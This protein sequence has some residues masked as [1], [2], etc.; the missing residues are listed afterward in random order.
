MDAELYLRSFRQEQAVL[1]RQRELRRTI[2]ERGG[3]APA[4]RGHG[5]R[6]VTGRAAGTASGDAL[7]RAVDRVAGW[8][9]RRHVAVRATA[10]SAV[11]CSP[12]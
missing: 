7:R 1:A 9:G 3:T 2:E 8:T 4:R 12:A 10:P 11:C 6:P 5:L